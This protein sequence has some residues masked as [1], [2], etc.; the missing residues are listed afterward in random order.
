M[1][2]SRCPR[3]LHPGPLQVHAALL[4]P[5]PFDPA[6]LTVRYLGGALPATLATPRCYTLTHSDL[7]ASLTLSIGGWAALKARSSTGGGVDTAA[8]LPACCLAAAPACSCLGARA[9]PLAAVCPCS[10]K[11]ASAPLR[12]CLMHVPTHP[13]TLPPPTHLPSLAPAPTAGPHYNRQQLSGWYTRILRDEILAEWQWG[14]AAAPAAAA[15][16]A[17]DGGWPTPGGGAVGPGSTALPALDPATATA[18][19]PASSSRST[20]RPPAREPPGAGQLS[21]SPSQLSLHIY[22]HV[23]GEEMWPAPPR[24]RSFIFQREMGLVLDTITHAE[25]GL[26]AACPDLAAAP[27]LVHLRSDVSELNRVVEWGQLGAP[28][29]WLRSSS[30]M[31]GSLLGSSSGSWAGSWTG[32]WAGSLGSALGSLFGS[33][34]ESLDEED[35]AEAA[36]GGGVAAPAGGPYARG[37]A[38]EACVAVDPGQ[39]LPANAAPPLDWRAGRAAEGGPQVLVTLRNGSATGASSSNGSSTAARSCAATM[40]GSSASASTNGSRRAASSSQSNALTLTAAAAGAAASVAGVTQ[41]HQ[42]DLD[43][44]AGR[45]WPPP[46]LELEDLAPL[47]AVEVVVLSEPSARK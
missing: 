20:L 25:A 2:L 31:L 35:G 10:P 39:Q 33:A 44:G 6:K 14:P 30:S 43:N 9:V 21:P 18:S 26:L 29:S 45:A 1:H 15:A 17:W 28:A 3:R 36:A 16:A 37:P 38:S 42:P 46:D 32:S 13:P 8:A 27:V 12:P 4:D 24:L 41:R 11:P 40:P 5:P 34:A 47:P 7:T 23:S 19:G 22:C